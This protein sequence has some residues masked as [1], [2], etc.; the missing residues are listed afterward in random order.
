MANKKENLE[1][2]NNLNVDALEKLICNQTE[3]S[4]AKFCPLLN[5][6]PLT[7]AS[8]R[9]QLKSLNEI[10]EYEKN[11]TKFKFLRMRDADEIVIGG[12]NIKYT[13]LIE[14]I[15]ANYLLEQQ[16]DI[17]FFSPIE[18]FSFLGIINF[19]YS[20][21]KD[22]NDKWYKNNTIREFYR[23]DFSL[24]EMNYFL[25]IAYTAILKPIIRNAIKSMDGKRLIRVQSAYNG[26]VIDKDNNKKYYKI[27]QTQEDGKIL[28]S[29]TARVLREFNYDGIQ[30][31]YFMGKKEVDKF[32]KRCNELCKENTMYDGYYDCYAIILNREGLGY[33]QKK[34]INALRYELNKRIIYSFSNNSKLRDKLPAKRHENLINA[35]IR[36]DSGYNL[37]QDYKAYK[38][39][40]GV[41]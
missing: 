3:I 19:N 36:L 7:G 27:L 17:V 33:Y 26:Y 20:F 28:S 16:Q 23:E 11:G 24:R 41:K 9:S 31:V 1:H 32:Y 30:F 5:L 12:K 2:L 40:S 38:K 10:C 18:L 34:D 4:Y 14:N 6:S 13:K 21:I 29:I 39:N 15:L 22:K 37:P 35:F 8:K 25:K